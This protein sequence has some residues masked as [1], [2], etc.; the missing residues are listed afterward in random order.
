MITKLTLKN[1]KSIGEQEYIFSGFDLLVGGNNSGKSTILQSLAI[2]QFCI[3][4]FRISKRSGATGTQV[5]LPNFTALPVP[6]FNLLWK[7]RTD[8][9]SIEK[10]EGGKTQELIPI[11]IRVEWQHEG[12]SESLAVELRYQS[13]QTIYAKPSVDHP[14][15]GWE[16]FRK[17]DQQKQLPVIAY[18]PPF[19]GLEPDEQGVDDGLL[20]QKVGKGQPGSILRNLLLRV[21]ESSE[22]EGKERWEE[23]TRAIK[24]WFS[25]DLQKPVYDRD[26]DVKIDVE[27]KQG[28]KSYDII[29]GGSGFHQTLTLLAF[30]YGY[31]PTTILLDEPDAH[32]HVNLQRLIIDFFKTK[33]QQSDVQFLIATHAEEFIDG[34]NMAHIISLLSRAPMRIESS[35]EII[36]AMADVSN[37]EIT[38]VQSA[39]F[40]IYLEGQSDERILR[41]WA[42]TF[43]M[44]MVIKKI[45]F[46]MMHG[47]DKPKMKNDAEEHFKA[48]RKIVPEVKRL[49]VFDYDDGR[50][51][52]GCENPVLYEWKRKNI[53]NYLLVPDAWKRCLLHPN[54]ELFAEP[55]K[56]LIDNFFNSENLTLPPKATWRDV[57]ANVF[58]IVDGKKILFE[59]D[60]SLFQ[61]LLKSHAIKLPR[62]D[63]AGFMRQE[64][65][66]T[67]VHMLMERIK[68]LVDTPEVEK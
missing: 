2:W 21:S 44:E 9:R 58:K 55:I 56:Q 12:Q 62:E 61:Q 39:P 28:K 24:T 48:L 19:S 26:R 53:E 51:S 17:Y 60:T 7:D 47:G 18:V 5:V 40:I 33:S 4:T 50:N 23:L 41:A 52:F 63:V 65:I 68:V 14:D 46:K 54:G 10:P 34:V 1:F 11:H 36:R 30:L 16:V 31:K 29:A 45:C 35:S 32:L 38:R 22:L 57:N 67:D 25:V 49:M 43:G 15:N 37:E 3:D 42:S 13:P 6:E 8:R 59:N 64:E 20:K 27:Y 66:H